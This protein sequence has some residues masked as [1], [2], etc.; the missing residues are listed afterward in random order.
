MGR[1]HR[2]HHRPQL[3]RTGPHS[4][5]CLAITGG[6]RPANTA[7]SAYGHPGDRLDNTL[8]RRLLA[9]TL[10]HRYSDLSWYLEEMPTQPALTLD[11]LA[12]RWWPWIPPDAPA[13][14]ESMIGP[15]GA[16]GDGGVATWG[17]V[18]A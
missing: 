16:R 3:S 10:L 15:T 5:G 8:Q 2:S 9:Y 12:T 6:S 4:T 14:Y 18:L 1:P 7:P 11:A 13:G 17:R